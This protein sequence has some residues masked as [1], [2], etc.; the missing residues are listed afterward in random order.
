MEEK[1]IHL[2]DYLRIVNK[3]KTTVLTF[4]ILTLLVVIIASFTATPLYQAATKVM[5][6]KNSA[7]ALTNAYTYTPYDPEFLETQFQLIKS[8]AVVEKVVKHLDPEKVYDLFFPEKEENAS[9]FSSIKEW[10][11][12][13]MAALKSLMGLDTFFSSQTAGGKNIPFEM[14]IPPTKAR[15]LEDVIRAGIQAE[16]VANSRIVEISFMSDNPAVATK[17]VNS[18]AQAY[19]DELLDMQMEVSGYSINWMSKKADIQQEKLEESERELHEYKRKHDIITIEDR[20][21]VLPERL[22]DLSKNLTQAETRRKEISAVYSQIRNTKKELLETIPVIVENSSVD[23][24]NKT[25]LAAEQKISELS[26]KY[27]EKHPRMI[28]AKNEL[29]DLKSKKYKELE[30]A[31]Q[32][33]ENEY[34]LASSNE[35]DLKELLDQTKFQAEKLG[36]KSIQLDILKRRVESNRFLYDSL[37]TKMKEKGITEQN[38]SVNVWVIEE[39]QMP[40]FPASPRKKRNILLGMILG[41]FGGIGL[42]FFLE[43]LDN[44]VK[45]PEDVEERFNVP[46]ISTIDLFKDKKETIVEN[47]L[48]STSS[49]TAENFK[50]LRTSIFLSSADHPPKVLLI[51]SMTPGEGKSSVCACLAATIAQTGKKVLII[52][53]DMRRPTQHK[54]FKTEVSLGLST[55]LAGLSMEIDEIQVQIREN[56]VLIPSGPVPPNPSE[57][58][59]SARLKTMLEQLGKRYDMIIIDTPPLASVTDPLILSRHVDGVIVVTW[60][61]KTT[62]EI[63]G[64]GL[65]QL[66][67]MSAPVT[68][69]VLNRFNAKKSGYY[70]NYGD[71][72]YSSDS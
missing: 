21:T 51:T 41:L 54:I 70:Y 36:E 32:T 50:G 61:G 22:S 25:I 20:Q 26:K 31:V 44:T 52:D 5:I 33:I 1:E 16:P 60:A 35:R 45:T 48:N 8:A 29:Q 14:K 69:V 55:F 18:I 43:Y 49:M 11:K 28:T 3:R 15:M 6:E 42:A 4:F 56:L 17:V 58:L 47:V 66:E 23:S 19:I 65:K 62:H 13:Q 72:Y 46:V 67:D 64:K 7:G 30:K 34:Q 68:G 9:Y 40:E 10:I 12:A 63:L 39:A 2:R 24:I 59:S 27:G 37:V 57:L 71:Y 53:A 38:Q